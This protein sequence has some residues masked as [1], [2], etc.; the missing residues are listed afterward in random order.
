MIGVRYKGTLEDGSTFDENPDV[1]PPLTRILRLSTFDEN[2]GSPQTIFLKKYIPRI[3]HL[4]RMRKK[5]E[6]ELT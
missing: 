3:G 4:W 5:Y 2:R 6:L 1:R